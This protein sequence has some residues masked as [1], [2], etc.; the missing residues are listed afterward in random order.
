MYQSSLYNHYLCPYDQISFPSLQQLALFEY[1]K[2]SKIILPS[3]FYIDLSTSSML[4][5]DSEHRL[6]Q[7]LYFA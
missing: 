2:L 5:L 1:I 7:A 4:L 3:F 6:N